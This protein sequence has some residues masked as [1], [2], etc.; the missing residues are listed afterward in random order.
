MENINERKY[1]QYYLEFNEYSMKELLTLC[2]KNQ[3]SLYGPKEV[4]VDRLAYH[5]SQ[6][7][8]YEIIQNQMKVC[9]QSIFEI[10]LKK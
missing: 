3:L 9:Y 1:H 6:L 10:F 2:E 5:F 7:K 8:R 4:I